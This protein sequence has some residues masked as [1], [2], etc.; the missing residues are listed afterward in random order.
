MATTGQVGKTL[1]EAS[2][3]H[4]QPV[5]GST[6]TTDLTFSQ[7]VLT[8]VCIKSGFTKNGMIG[9]TWV[10]ICIVLRVLWVFTKLI[11][12]TFSLV[13]VMVNPY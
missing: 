6:H 5:R 9:S 13:A 4:R 10:A 7:E 1:V 2:L 3:V 11:T 8:D 12:S